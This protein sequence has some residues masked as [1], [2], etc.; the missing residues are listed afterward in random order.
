MLSLHSYVNIKAPSGA[1]LDLVNV[2]PVEISTRYNHNQ[3]H[4]VSIKKARNSMQAFS[5]YLNSI[6]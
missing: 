5:K 6:K 2:D 4:K 3:K 1:F